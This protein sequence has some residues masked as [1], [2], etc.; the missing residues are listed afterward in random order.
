MNI[1]FS[2]LWAGHGG[3]FW[4]YRVKTK[5][6]RLTVIL[7]FTLSLLHFQFYWCHC[8]SLQYYMDLCTS[9]MSPLQTGE[10]REITHLQFT[11]WID[12]EVPPAAEVLD[13]LFHVRSTQEQAAKNM[14]SSWTGHPLGPPI[15]VHCSAGIG[16]TG[17]LASFHHL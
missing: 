4:R 11:S 6:Y 15:I 7:N 14:A 13:F 17:N 10:S 5:K 16:R 12:Y 2:D 8:C 3:P 1:F 9:I